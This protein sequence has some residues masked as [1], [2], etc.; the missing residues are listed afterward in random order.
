M[1]EPGTIRTVAGDVHLAD[2]M[3]TGGVALVHEHLSCDLSIGFGPEYVLDDAELVANELQAAHAAGVRLMVDVGNSGHLRDPLFLREVAS[4]GGMTVMASAGHY[5]EGF[6]PDVVASQSVEELTAEIVREIEHGIGQTT[7][8]AGAIAEIGMS[9]ETA[10]PAEKKA[11]AAS[12]AAQAQTGVPLMTHTAQGVGWR[13]QIEM[14]SDGGADL[15]RVVIGHMDCLDDHEAHVGVI[16]SGAWLGFD[17]VNSL[18]YQSDE[19]RAKRLADL[20]DA[21]HGGRVVL[22]TDTA[23]VTRLST[24]G[25]AGYMAVLTEFVPLL[26]QHGV[27]EEWIKRISVDNAWEFLGGVRA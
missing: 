8:R 5:R 26:R 20:I 4:R 23:M 13:A 25:G 11:F 3:A 15:N 16:E 22:S 27:S 14:L 7:V 12:A 19:V 10:T 18:R 17:R 9:G 24:R 6:F 21:G 2:L 1:L